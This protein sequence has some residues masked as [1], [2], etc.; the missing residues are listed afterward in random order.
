MKTRTVI[1]NEETEEE[2][3]EIRILRTREA[4][5]R[6]GKKKTRNFFDDIIK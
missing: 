5:S 4:G 3:E 1:C 6:A 2:E